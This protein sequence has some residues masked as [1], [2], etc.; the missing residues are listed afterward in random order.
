MTK[1]KQH[2]FY[3]E[4]LESIKNNDSLHSRIYGYPR[5]G[6]CCEIKAL[7]EGKNKIWSYEDLEQDFP[8]LYSLKPKRVGEFWFPYTADGWKKRL[9]LL[10]KAIKLSAPKT[11]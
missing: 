6:L 8:I 3:K 9:T 7:M 5:N 11:K 4:L 10:R 1:A 2:I